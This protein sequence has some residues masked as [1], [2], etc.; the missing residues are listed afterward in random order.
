MGRPKRDNTTVTPGAFSAPGVSEGSTTGRIDV[1]LEGSGT[2]TIT[3]VPEELNTTLTIE[4][5]TPALLKVKPSVK[6][7]PV[8]VKNIS[9]T[10]FVQPD[11]FI[12]IDRGETKPLNDDGW[13]FQQIQAGFLKKV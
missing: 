4:A 11:T 8:Q 12:R 13:L 9:K 2:G 5:E 7:P 6:R 10:W 3:L 1:G